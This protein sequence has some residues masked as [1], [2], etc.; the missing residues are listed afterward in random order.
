MPHAN[1]EP[2]D[3]LRLQLLVLRC[4]AGDAQAFSAL[5]ERFGPRTQRYLRSLLGD[6]ADDA[7]QEVWIAVYR[8]VARLANPAGFRTW[9]FTIT[10]HRALDYLRKRRRH[11]ALIE[12]VVADVPMGDAADEGGD[13]APDLAHMETA[14]VELPL[15][16]REVLLLRF[17]DEMTYAEIA[18]ITGCPLGTVKTR[19]HHARRNLR[20]LLNRSDS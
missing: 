6:D 14:M 20:R 19:I 13:D 2:N 17:R 16:Q 10:R 12:D 11:E 3:A 8:S 9:L 18:V 4:Q 5:L 1:P 7:Q 15:A